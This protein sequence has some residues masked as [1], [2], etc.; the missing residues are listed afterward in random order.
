MK[1][2]RLLLSALIIAV[3]LSV[4]SLAHAHQQILKPELIYY[5]QQ[6]VANSAL[7]DRDLQT[8]LNLENYSGYR[9]SS[10]ALEFSETKVPSKVKLYISEVNQSLSFGIEY[11]DNDGIWMQLPG[12][13]NISGYQ[14]ALGWNSWQISESVEAEA[15][16]LF[17]YGAD[18]PHTG[19]GEMEVW[20]QPSSSMV[21]EYSCDGE[22]EILPGSQSKGLW[23]FTITSNLERLKQVFLSYEVYDLGYREGIISIN[24]QAFWQTPPLDTY[25][26]WVKISEELNP[27]QFDIGTSTIEFRNG[28]SEE[29]GFRVRNLKICLIFDQGQIDVQEVIGS[30]N[31]S[32]AYGAQY[33]IDQQLTTYWE[34]EYTYPPNATLEFDLG[35]EYDVEYLDL[36][37]AFGFNFRAQI[38]YYKN[39]TW[40]KY[41]TVAEFTQQQLNHGWNTFYLGDEGVTTDKLRISFTNLQGHPVIGR[42]YEVAL[43]GSRAVEKPKVPEVIITNPD[44]GDYVGRSTI[45]KGFIR[46]QASSL[47]INGKSVEL[48]AGTFESEIF[49]YDDDDFHDQIIRTITVTAIN[50][51]GAQG[52]S[53]VTVSRCKPPKVE[54]TSPE[55]EFVTGASSITIKGTIDKSV[56][57]LTLNG[58]PIA[59]FAGQFEEVVS[60]N[61][62]VNLFIIKAI[63]SQGLSSEDQ[64]RVIRDIEPPQLEFDYLYDGL[65]TTENQLMISGHLFDY[66]PAILKIN[67]QV[68]PVVN[69][70][71][72]WPVLLFEGSNL[73]WVVAEDGYGNERDL[74]IEVKKDTTPPIPFTPIAEPSGW[75]DNREPVITFGT[76]DEI[77]GIDHYELRIDDGNFLIAVSPY[78]LPPLSDGIHTI[79]IKAVD[80]VGWEQL[81]S[82]QVF[83]DTT[84]PATPLDFKVIS[85]DQRVLI[86]WKANAE[87]DFKKY[88][89]YR[90][91]AFSGGQS[92]IEF[93]PVMEPEYV[94]IDVTNGSEYSYQISAV[95]HI[96]NESLGTSSQTVQPGPIEQPIDPNEGGTVEYDQVEVE[97]PAGA[98]SEN[99]DTTVQILAVKE[100]EIPETDNLV[101]GKTYAFNLVDENNQPEQHSE[102]LEPVTLEFAYNQDEIPE[103]YSVLDLA[104]YHYDARYAAWVMM[105]DAE[106]DQE[107]GTI[108][109]Q[110]NHFSMYNV[111][112]NTSYTPE[113]ARYED[114]GLSPY[115]TYFRDRQEI[116]APSNGNL[117]LNITDLSIPGRNGLDL[118]LQRFY[119]NTSAIFQS[120]ETKGEE[121][122]Q[123]FGHGWS[124]GIPRIQK[125][126]HGQKIYFADGSAAS[127][128]WKMD[129]DGHSGAGHG[130]VE[131]HRGRHFTGEKYQV[132][133]SDVRSSAGRAIGEEWRDTDIFITMKDG[134]C[135]HFD[136]AGKI[137]SITDRTG[138]NQIEFFYIGNKFN[139]IRDSV[140]REVIFEYT[141]EKITKITSGDISYQYQYNGAGQLERVIDP[142][143]RVTSYVYGNEKLRYGGKRR[144][145]VTVKLGGDTIFEDSDQDGSIKSKNVPVLKE[146]FYPSGGKTVYVYDVTGK[147]KSRNWQSEK[148]KTYTDKELGT[149]TVTEITEFS[150]D[151]VNETKVMVTAQKK[152]L[153]QNTGIEY[154]QTTYSYQFTDDDPNKSV[155]LATILGSNGQKTVLKFQNKLNVE[156]KQYLGDDLINKQVST[157]YELL[158][159]VKE[160][161]LYRQDELVLEKK[162]RYDNW[163]NLVYEYNSES[164]MERYAHYLNTDSSLDDFPASFIRPVDVDFN[165]VNVEVFNLLADSFLLNKNPIE[166]D[167]IAIRSHFVYSTTGNLI[168]QANWDQ[169]KQK[170]LKNKFT[171]DNYG[172]VVK[173]IDAL[174][175]ET[176]LEYDDTVH[177]SAYLTKT[178]KKGKH[179]GAVL[180]GKNQPIPGNYIVTQMGYDQLTGLKIWEIDAL[181]YLTEFRYDALKRLT[182]IIYPDDDDT[183]SGVVD[184]FNI[185]NYSG[186]T[187]NP[188]KI[189]L[190]E[191]DFN[192]TT[193]V[194]AY[195]DI[196]LTDVK[197][198]DNSLTEPVFNKNRY[199][200]DGLDRWVKSEAF[201]LNQDEHVEV[202]IT[203]FYY[204]QSDRRVAVKD[205]EGHVTFTEY[206]QLNRVAKIIY[207]DGS[208]DVHNSADNQLFSIIEYDRLLNK[209]TIIDAKGNK[210]AE[211]K[212][213]NGN[214]I[215][216]AK[217]F[218]GFWLKST[219]KYDQVGNQVEVVDGEGRISQFKYDSLNRLVAEI[220]PEDQLIKPLTPGE[221][222]MIGDLTPVTYKPHNFYFYD[223]AGRKIREIRA[224]SYW[225]YGAEVSNSSVY[226]YAY[227]AVGNL[228]KMTNPQ[229]QI[230][231]QCYN[232]RGELVKFEDAAGNISQKMYNARGW[233]VAE[234]LVNGLLSTEA[235]VSGENGDHDQITYYTYDLIGNRVSVT[236]PE[237]VLHTTTSG[238]DTVTLFT[239]EIYEHHT[240]PYYNLDSDYTHLIAYDRF[241]NVIQES[242]KIA[243]VDY[244]TS[245]KYDKV[246]NQIQI[247]NPE[248]QRV[249]Y[250]YTP[251]YWLAEE[252][253]FDETGK[254]Y[255]TAYGNDQVGNKIKVTD[256]AN[257]VTYN[258]YDDLNRLI[259]TI[260]PDNTNQFFY[261]DKVGNQIKVIDGNN[262][263]TEYRYN[264]QNQLREVLDAAAGTTKY[265]YDPEGNLMKKV[266]P[267]NLATRY[268]YDQL[269]YIVR[270][271]RP[272]GDVI[273]YSY[274]QVGNLKESVDRKGQKTS[275]LYQRNYLPLQLDYFDETGSLVTQTTYQYDRSGQRLE[276]RNEHS[277]VLYQYDPLG[278]I[279]EESREIAG[280]TYSTGY[281]YDKVGNIRYIKYPKSDTWVEYKYNQLN[282]LVGIT[283]FLD[284]TTENPAFTY[285]DNGFLAGIRY[286][287]GTNTEITPD[288]NSRVKDLKV[289][290]GSN[291]LLDISYAYDGN[292]NVQSRAN[293]LTGMSNYYYYD[294]LDRLTSADVEG[295]FY[296]ERTGFAGVAEED[297]FENL[298]LVKKADYWVK[299]DYQANSVGV[300]LVEAA[301][302][303]RIE[304]KPD[305]EVFEHRID[306]SNLSV[307]YSDDN[308]IYNRLSEELW[309]FE[310][311]AD[312]DITIIF[313]NPIEVLA[314]KVHSRFDDR[315][316]YFGFVDKSEFFGDLREMVKVYQRA[317]DARL[318]YNYDSGG[319]RTAK[320]VIVGNTDQTTYDYYAGSNRLKKTT[321]NLTGE[322]FYYVYDKNG[323]LLEKGNDYQVNLDSSV[324]FVKER[325]AEYWRYEY[326]VKDRLK[327]VYRNEVLVAEFI[328]DVDGKRVQSETQEEGKVSYIF[329]FGGKVLY[330]EH[331]V[332]KKTSYIYAHANQ[333]A[334]VEGIVGGDGEI[335]YYHHDNLG[336][337]RVM[338]DSQGKIVWE[339]DYMPFGEDLHKPGTVDVDYDINAEYKFTGQREVKGIG[340]Y[341]YG[342]RHYDPEI[343]RFI[344]EDS[345]LGELVNPQ[346]QNLYIYVMNN[347]LKY[348]DPTGNSTEDAFNLASIFDAFKELVELF[349][350]GKMTLFEVDLIETVKNGNMELEDMEQT[351]S[352]TFIDIETGMMINDYSMYNFNK[353]LNLC[354][355]N[356][357]YENFFSLIES[358][359]FQKILE[360]IPKNKNFHVVGIGYG[361]GSTFGYIPVGTQ[362]A[363]M[364]LFDDKGNIGLYG[365]GEIGLYIGIG[366]SGGPKV[367]VS[368]AQTIYDVPSLGAISVGGEAGVNMTN[369]GVEGSF[370]SNS[371]TT[372]FGVNKGVYLLGGP[373]FNIAFNVMYNPSILVLP[374]NLYDNPNIQKI[375]SIIQSENTS[376]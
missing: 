374:T 149:I 84:P 350:T 108:K 371:I 35:G 182:K 156:R 144:V 348:I 320:R 186:R 291:K 327:A 245:Y 58:Q 258:R 346:S 202:G 121:V 243:G 147:N 24:G 175:N 72:Y 275:F 332:E 30:E 256:P 305:R 351:F 83:I 73:F 192:Q 151:I 270:E 217:L 48:D 53:Q 79:E 2:Y 62:G 329:N 89:L 360:M 92:Y 248:G 141:G 165:Q 356:E 313:E 339:Q 293:H 6:R 187:N 102:F 266:L 1:W 333:I 4:G 352:N 28:S 232:P 15:I 370:S 287:N 328:Y 166:I 337:T 54:I 106:I 204:D 224:N 98:I 359:E 157:Y 278:R 172:N 99:E 286:N 110:S 241:S 257:K 353:T 135:Y 310:K 56:S 153:E 146:I 140:G 112:L 255:L 211:L 244:I 183:F 281:R 345:Y 78:Q 43:W 280:A 265:Y 36:Y 215:E 37:Q 169:T 5:D 29:N 44:D 55:D 138:N 46:G 235:D 316:R 104:V 13:G 191:D 109:I 250:S 298:S 296:G 133:I 290:S 50:D 323:N 262:H 315:D 107:R 76:F 324:E 311:D 216:V 97:I 145:K 96:G 94:D 70:R 268:V 209:Q 303:G 167:P 51:Q 42:I 150:T 368:N 289:T 8:V 247:I 67:E 260:L 59:Y 364:V 152:F 57:E 17:I 279:T 269:G 188:V 271:V 213:W 227:D 214:T 231:Y 338:T 20:G 361:A 75:T 308:L 369:I 113:A 21:V 194:N 176:V 272:E 120:L 314:F 282:Q 233:L 177:G 341:Y 136:G 114:L 220:L 206:D 344:T 283:G 263:Q 91:P 66:S 246:G 163:G 80:L 193:V 125:D 14:L 88:R 223:D 218:K 347:P 41:Q 242:R 38:E 236:T 161:K 164:G 297:I 27:Q 68:V 312:G 317:D 295:T 173:I 357:I 103:E 273:K 373:N 61:H 93:D 90:T 16:R 230:S 252:K 179:G 40:V 117:V 31:S 249:E 254:E 168:L 372:T 77:T 45:V 366:G 34:T 134:L 331:G 318:E 367:L 184:H 49:F 71:F 127:L 25:S 363:A 148:T 302:I 190:Y 33:V 123:T 65:V 137:L 69:G 11:R 322:S 330:E 300:I 124:L 3:F 355:V 18:Q 170:W 63:D 234:A 9:Y 207:P 277:A 200:Y 180:D 105:P 376:K 130:T 299:F 171:Y 128:L 229:N 22:L 10:F 285:A 132:K 306:K 334:R 174:Q 240:T 264:T 307:Y 131:Y 189:Q 196:S 139:K 205:A 81:A 276:A 64:V 178:I 274:D 253:V 309:R 116:V 119:D 12:T 301:E 126:D 321:N 259:E 284:G 210:T 288:A 115:Q 118:V 261:Y 203:E 85:G 195:Q 143:N 221:W 336:S 219:A 343:G 267:N 181:G 238:A 340:L 292:N 19:I 358:D 162:Y 32:L 26:E 239:D 197:L 226:E 39:Q 159:A 201:N 225:L 158:K 228:V 87:P 7:N 325:P 251:Q 304:L 362:G 342:A 82:V 95:D 375:F 222:E 154:G 185:P 155:Q 100:A 60:L 86:N 326:T 294:Q 122:Y 365:S 199:Y 160:E 101:I 142:L 129:G 111:Q 198:T 335:I 354:N 349:T 319:N 212:D 52:V 23:S 208:K 237:G 47:K 74:V